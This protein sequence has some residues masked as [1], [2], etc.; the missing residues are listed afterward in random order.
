M[1]AILAAAP[2]TLSAATSS[3]VFD[4]FAQAYGQ[5]KGQNDI[6]GHK[7]LVDYGSGLQYKEGGFWYAYSD[8]GSS[9]RD[10]LGRDMSKTDSFV[11]AQA[12]GVLHAKIKTSASTATD[13]YAAIEDLFVGASTYYDFTNLSSV[14]LR[15]KGTFTGTGD[16][17]FNFLTKDVDTSGDWGNY[18]Y[19]LKALSSGYTIVTIPAASITAT[20]YSGTAKSSTWKANGAANVRGLQFKVTNGSDAE[21]YI[22]SI[23]FVGIDSTTFGLGSSG[24]GTG[25]GTPT[26]NTTTSGDTTTL[27]DFVQA[28]GQGKGQNDIAAYYGKVTYGTGNEYKAGGFWFGY[29]DDSGSTITDSTGATLTDGVGTHT[30]ANGV[31]HAKLNAVSTKT[32]AYSGIG[33]HF[34]GDSDYVNLTTLKSVLIRL[35]GTLSSGNTLRFSVSNKYIDSTGDWGTFGYDIT[36]LSSNYTILSIPVASITPTKYST[37]AAAN[38][39]FAA[40]GAL[41]TYGLKFQITKGTADLDL[42]YIKF[43]GLD[44]SVLKPGTTGIKTIAAKSNALSV[45]RSGDIARVSYTLS[46]ATQVQAQIVDA[47]GRVISS[48]DRLQRAGSQE[49]ELQAPVGKIGFLRLKTGST[50]R[51]AILPVR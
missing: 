26:D 39:T 32:D 11:G 43:V 45:T 51:T 23:A 14:V 24:S 42:D 16:L 4:G 29:A 9:I 30:E 13:T 15:I 25:T 8:A 48:V 2:A 5:G 46:E 41:E 6:A 36:T 38:V 28:Y 1:M 20:L 18:G 37:A 12:N 49:L 10:S 50:V 21:I 34:F 40:K 19:S 17:R 22:D 7:G 47:K 3:I 27:D 44:T 31:F 35:K 33:V